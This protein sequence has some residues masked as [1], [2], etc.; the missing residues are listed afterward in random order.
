MSVTANDVTKT[1]KIF[2]DKY[3]AYSGRHD[4]LCNMGYSRTG[5]RT[6]TITFVNTGIYTYD[7]LRVVSPPVKGIE[8]KTAK[9]GQETLE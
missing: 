2:T 8:E 7:K 1:V 9:L 4:F 6:M 3:N 5:L